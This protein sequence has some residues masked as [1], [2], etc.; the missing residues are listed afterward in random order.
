MSPRV[1]KKPSETPKGEKIK[2]IYQT[3]TQKIKKYEDQ[4]SNLKTHA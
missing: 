2:Q 4:N 1:I 3:L